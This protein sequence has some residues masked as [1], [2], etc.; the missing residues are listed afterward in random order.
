MPYL[1]F[2]S[3]WK[4]GLLILTGLILMYVSY[5]IYAENRESAEAVQTFENFSENNNFYE[6]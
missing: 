5:V 4:N 3:D 6:K 2:P 1:G